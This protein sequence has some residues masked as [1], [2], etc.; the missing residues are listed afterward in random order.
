[1]NLYRVVFD[2][3]E[4]I[5]L[6]NLHLADYNIAQKI[7]VILI[8]LESIV[9]NNINRIHIKDAIHLPKLHA[10]LLLVRKFVWN[11]LKVHFTLQIHILKSNDS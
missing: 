10:N 2:N 4:V 8:L 6:C 7:G 11:A 5:D 9:K 3:Y 1:M